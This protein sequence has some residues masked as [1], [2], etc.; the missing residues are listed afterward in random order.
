M[1]QTAA[2]KKSNFAS[3]PSHNYQT[4]S[5][6]SGYNFPFDLPKMELVG[7]AV[8][9]HGEQLM[10][11]LNTLAFVSVPKYLA[12]SPVIGRRNRLIDRLE[13]QKRIAADPSY[14]PLTKRW[15]KTP[16]G[17]KAL[18][19]HY[20]RI[21]PW[22]RKD[23]AGNLILTVRVGLKALEF[24]KGKAGIAVGA[25][26]RLESVLDTLIAATKAGELD[27]FLEVTTAP[28]GRGIPKAKKAA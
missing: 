23:D 1:P 6:N 5:R 12:L 26:E 18:V 3:V 2:S 20:H 22:W 7:E 16:D 17:S 27:R 24:E 15:K 9:V 11:H 10:T 8:I 21:R 25:P 13:E 14:I 28:E 4:I 19:D